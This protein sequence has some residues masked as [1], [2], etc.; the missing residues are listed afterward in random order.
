[1]NNKNTPKEKRVVLKDNYD[2]LKALAHKTRLKIINQLLK[3]KELSCTQIKNLI[4]IPQPT[5]SYHLEV[6]KRE[7]IITVKS[8]GSSHYYQLIPQT[9]EKYGVDYQKLLDSKN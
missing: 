8:S 1:M 2:F 9:F 3:N 4:Q 5:L 6:L 7:K